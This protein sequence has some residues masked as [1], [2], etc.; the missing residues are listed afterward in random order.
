MIQDFEAKLEECLAVNDNRNPE[1]GETE[2]APRRINVPVVKRPGRGGKSA[3]KP[4]PRRGRNKA[5]SSESESDNE[6]ENKP[7]SRA[8]G[9]G[10][11]ERVIESDSEEEPILRKTASKPRAARATKVVQ[12][13][14]SSGKKRL[15]ENNSF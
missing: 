7:P 13:A 15:S 11:V 8:K 10:K 12:D 6:L 4:P 5:S 2:E 9:R 14:T 1:D 3:K